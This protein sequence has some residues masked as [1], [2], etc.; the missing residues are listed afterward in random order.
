MSYVFII[1]YILQTHMQK[2]IIYVF[3]AKQTKQ[4]LIH[5][6]MNTINR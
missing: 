1:T 3:K 4:G 6:N 5:I 2:K